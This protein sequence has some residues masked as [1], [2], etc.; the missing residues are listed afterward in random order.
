MAIPARS[1]PL[2][3]VKVL[4][5][6]SVRGVLGIGIYDVRRTGNSWTVF[7]HVTFGPT[8]ES[9]FSHPRRRTEWQPLFTPRCAIG[10]ACKNMR[11]ASPGIP[12]RMVAGRASAAPGLQLRDLKRDDEI[13]FDSESLN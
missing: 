8:T 7:L 12:H 1:S 6:G 4:F 10:T 5:Q 11:L 3:V 13:S 2:A 9:D